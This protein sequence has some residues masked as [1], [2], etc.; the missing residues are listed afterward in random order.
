M[1]KYRE[2]TSNDLLEATKNDAPGMM[3]NFCVLT[4]E[5]AYTPDKGTWASTYTNHRVLVGQKK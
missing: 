4:L 3:R 5:A 2:N 1:T